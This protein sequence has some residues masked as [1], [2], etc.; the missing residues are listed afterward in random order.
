LTSPVARITS[1]MP[2]LHVCDCPA[3]NANNLGVPS[4][5]QYRFSRDVT[6]TSI[7]CHSNSISHLP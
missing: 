7:R 1:T 4:D 5:K 2:N 6:M 3:G